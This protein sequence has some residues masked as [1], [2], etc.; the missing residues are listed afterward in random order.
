MQ[1][2][3]ADTTPWSPVRSV[4]GGVIRFKNLLDGQERTP[5]NFSL[6]I[7][8]TDVSFKSPRHRHNFDQ[9][10]I[11]LQGST[12]YG[13]HEN[14]EV[15]DVV[16]FP[17]GTYYGPQDQ[18]L[19]KASSVAMVIQFG[20]ASGNGYMSTRELFDGQ[21]KLEAVGRF[22]GG[23]F[24]HGAPADGARKNQDA[25]EAIWEDQN[26]RPIEYPRPRLSQPVHFRA[27]HFPWQ[28]VTGQDGVSR[29]EL[30]RFGER[31]VHLFVL[32]LESGVSCVL[33]PTA[34]QRLLFVLCGS[35]RVGGDDGERWAPHSAAHLDAGEAPHLRVEETTELLVLELP[36]FD[37]QPQ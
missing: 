17:E 9:L 13:P 8:D 32:R 21:K 7:A 35:G 30:G 24:R 36:R 3:H 6:V 31:D 26:G 19:T 34:Q 4:R 15:G 1:I 16:Y 23:V 11:T 33:P 22:E 18:Q 5:N 2:A 14:I 29:R 28:P 20:G 12:N 10:R 37:A 25:Y 27:T